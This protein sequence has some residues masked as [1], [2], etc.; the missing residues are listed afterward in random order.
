MVRYCRAVQ[1]YD[2]NHAKVIIALRGDLERYRK[3][4]TQA[5]IQ[6]GGELKVGR[7]PRSGLERALGDYLNR[8]NED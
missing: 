8:M 1:G 5:L 7:A 6:L 2:K 4:I 3:P